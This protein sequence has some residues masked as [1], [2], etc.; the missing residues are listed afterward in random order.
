MATKFRI[1]RMKSSKSRNETFLPLTESK[2]LYNETINRLMIVRK[3]SPVYS[4][5]S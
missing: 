3:M 2:L 5:K 4:E 1:P